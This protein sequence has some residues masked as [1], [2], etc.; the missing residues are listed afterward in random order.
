[1]YGM[2]ETKINKA[3]Y[4]I[5]SNKAFLKS[6]GIELDNKI[7][8]FASFVKNS[9]INA[10]RYIAELQHRAHSINEYAN[11]KN[12]SNVFLTLTLSSEWH[13][14]KQKSKNDK[15]LIFNKKFGGR[16][17]ITKITDP[18][19]GEVLKLLNT[20]AM[21]DK[22]QPRNAS[23]ELSKLLTK[24][25]NERSYRNIDKD[26]RCYFRVTE[27]HADGTPHVHVSYF[28][29]EIY[30][31]AFVK[32]IN[33]LYPSP[34]SKIV[35]DVDSPVHY[36]MK[37][38]LKT[39][40]DLREDNDKLTSLTLW[41]VYHGISRFYTS[42]TFLSLDIYR[43]LNGMY[44]LN[45]LK[46]SYMNKEV[47]IYYYKD[48]KD[49][50]KIENEH[51]AIYIPKPL[52]GEF[53]IDKWKKDFDKNKEKFEEERE[54]ILA[55]D[56]DAI[57]DF[58]L[59]IQVKFS[60]PQ[61]RNDME[62]ED[63]TYYEYEFEPIKIKHKQPLKDYL[64]QDNKTYL[65]KKG[66]MKDVLDSTTGEITQEQENATFIEIKKQPYQMSDY[67][68]K[69]YFDNIEIDGVNLARYIYTRNLMLDRGLL[70]GERLELADLSE[71]EGAF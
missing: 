38:I 4:K 8:P 18:R 40:D 67:E 20:Q 10:D 64:E 33:R 27:P 63:N 58:P 16:K 31:D 53:A 59:P 49:I 2:T 48:T 25:Y 29:P 17:Y 50:A 30:K 56:P 32:S 11:K 1:M 44:T 43:K 60:N 12:L 55:F 47:S 24:L 41:Y 70:E 5:K 37:Y 15:T 13:P 65:I 19:T 22:Y 62:N 23:K 71:A 45:E 3:K 35:L 52:F 66:L 42:R 54:A 36:L 51:G 68:L 46:E 39:L 7:I 14:M 69:K 26:D 21:I 57:V 28:M 34:Q 6:H 9:Y 61:W